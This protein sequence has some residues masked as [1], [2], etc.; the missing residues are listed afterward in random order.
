MPQ[1]PDAPRD[2]VAKY[3]RPCQRRNSISPVNM[4][5]NNAPPGAEPPA[6]FIRMKRLLE[7][8][9][10]RGLHP[11][12]RP[13]PVRPAIICTRLDQINLLVISVPHVSAIQAP[14]IE[15]DAPRV[16]QSNRV[17]FRAQTRGINRPA[18]EAIDAK[19]G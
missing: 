2:V 5:A 7:I 4:S 15:R 10:R 3:I 13:F 19:K 18:I 8:A 14:V 1:T 6:V 11:I 17:Q 12:E 16:S 9:S